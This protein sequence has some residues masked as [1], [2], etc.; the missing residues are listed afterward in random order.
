MVERPLFA[1]YA[2]IALAKGAGTYEAKCSKAFRQLIRIV[3]QV[4]LRAELREVEKALVLDPTLRVARKFFPG[5][6]VQ[7]LSGPFMGMSGAVEWINTKRLV[8]QV[9]VA[10]MGTS[11][12]IELPASALEPEG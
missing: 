4:K 10:T 12:N 8:M 5:Q 3:E 2:F 6:A 1:G 9:R 11:V 7:V